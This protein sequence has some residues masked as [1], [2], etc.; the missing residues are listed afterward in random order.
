MILELI[1]LR[2]T[3][4]LSARLILN[5]RQWSDQIVV[6]TSVGQPANVQQP[7]AIWLPF[8]AATHLTGTDEF[9][10]DPLE[11]VYSNLGV[12]DEIIPQISTGDDGNITEVSRVP[13]FSYS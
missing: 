11:Y 10:S 7:S 2:V 8:H 4:L 3:G 6:H 12:D 1:I 9:G 5:L 13:S